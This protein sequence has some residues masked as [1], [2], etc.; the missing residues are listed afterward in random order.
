MTHLPL[1]QPDATLARGDRCGGGKM[2]SIWLV[3]F[4][5]MAPMAPMAGAETLQHGNIIY[6]LPANWDT[7]ILEDGIQTLIHDPPDEA[8]EYCYL[9]LGP[10]AAKSGSLVDYVTEVGPSFVDADDRGSIEVVQPAEMSSIG[11][12]NVALYAFR[13]DGDPFFVFGFELTDRFEVI[14]FEGYA[15]YEGEA[16]DATMATLQ[17]QVVPMLSSLQFVSEGAASLMP[18]PTP[19]PLQGVWWGWYQYTGLGMDMMVRLEIDHRRLVFWNDGYF[20]DGTPPTGLA[21]LDEAA[22]RAAGDGQFGTYAKIGSK[23]ELTFATGER[24]SLRLIDDGGLQDDNRDLFAYDTVADGTRLNG[25]VSS[26]FYSGFTPG[27]G[28]EGGVSSS[29]STTFLPDGT[30]TGE[31]FGGA[32]GNFVDGGGS[33]TGGFATGGDG[34]A[35][36]G[37]YEIRDGVLIQYPHDGSPPSVSMVIRTEEGLLIDDQ[38]F[39]PAE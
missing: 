14:A 16:M 33:T 38:F 4:L 34:N 31:S 20:Y 5:A 19:G 27:A 10:G 22:L 29:S 35:T 25:G 1:G 13:A 8:C 7:G 23:V 28:I 39:E 24:E 11:T 2:R 12:V 9:H 15:G 3:M 37:R 30:Y 6:S 26:F 32:F 17:N 18:A 36:G 21:P